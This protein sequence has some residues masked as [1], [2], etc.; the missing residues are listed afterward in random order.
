MHNLTAI[1][2]AALSV[3]SRHHHQVDAVAQWKHMASANPGMAAF[4]AFLIIALIS[5]AV[6]VTRKG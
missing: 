1:Q 4:L 5:V 2:D 3:A 6:M